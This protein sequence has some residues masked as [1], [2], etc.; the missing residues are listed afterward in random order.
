MYC[1]IWMRN[2]KW[3]L[4]TNEIWDTEKEA[5]KYAL[6]KHFKKKH[7]WKVVNYFKEYRMKSWL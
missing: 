1:I 7:K 2:D 4:F 3:E 5:T 6:K